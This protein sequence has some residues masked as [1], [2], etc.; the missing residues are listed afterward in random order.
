MLIIL[1][2]DGVI[3]ADSD[4]YIKSPDE[5]HALP[6]SLEAI[7]TLSK[8]GHKVVVATNQS[9]VGRGYY[10][11]NMLQ[12][13]HEKMQT[14]LA[15]HGGKLT[16]IYFCPHTPDDR[17]HC[18]K[19]EPGLLEKIK[20]DFPEEFSNAV[21]IGDSYRDLQA[22]HKMKIKAILVKTG[23]GK[24]TLEKNKDEINEV[25]DDL[26]AYVKIMLQSNH[27]F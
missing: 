25:Y 6:G 9:G 23:N 11:L 12:K 21:L 5:W 24:K 19:P 26:K 17:C 7:A 16:G 22:A 3:N 8:A 20:A 2:R 27:S 15:K 10:D 18:R 13:I 14:E 1:D 4:D